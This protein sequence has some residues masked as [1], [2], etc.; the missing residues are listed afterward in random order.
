MRSSVAGPGS[1]Q[2][3]QAVARGCIRCRMQ[4][5]NPRVLPSLAAGALLLALTSMPAWAA[6]PVKTAA[7]AAGA[8]SIGGAL[9]GG[10]IISAR[11]VTLAPVSGGTPVTVPIAADGTFRVTGLGPGRYRL[12]LASGNA[13]KQTQGATFGEKVNAGMASAGSAMASGVGAKHDTAKNSVGNI[14]GREAPASDPAVD[15]TSTVSSDK[16]GMNGMPNRISMNVTTPKQTYV[17]EVDGA[18]VDLDVGPDGVLS[19]RVSVR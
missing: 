12:S 18:S 10:A 19:G 15:A 4:H 9:P 13:A 8:T 6:D 16:V 3:L 11:S 14:R 5:L 17:V 7:P 1:S 2:D